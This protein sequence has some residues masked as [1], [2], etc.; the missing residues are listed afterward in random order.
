[1]AYVSR[2]PQPHVPTLETR[3]QKGQTLLALCMALSPEVTVG[4][5]LRLSNRRWHASALAVGSQLVAACASA[6]IALLNTQQPRTD[7]SLG[8]RPS[9][10]PVSHY[11]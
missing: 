2:Q 3:R 11:G 9:N 5:S 6:C 7:C 8:S 1:M 10:T 4:Q